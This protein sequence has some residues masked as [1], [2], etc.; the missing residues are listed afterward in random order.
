MKVLLKTF[1]MRTFLR[2]ADCRS[3]LLCWR[4]RTVLSLSLRFNCQQHSTS[5]ANATAECTKFCYSAQNTRHYNLNK[6]YISQV[7][8]WR[9]TLRNWRLCQ[10]QSHLTQKLGQISKIWPIQMYTLYPSLRIR[11]RTS[12]THFIKSTQKSKPKKKTACMTHSY[13][14]QQVS[15]QLHQ[16]LSEL[17]HAG[18]WTSERT[19]KCKN[20][21]WRDGYLI[22]SN[23]APAVVMYLVIISIMIQMNNVHVPYTHNCL[24]K[25]PVAK[26]S[27]SV[28]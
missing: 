9:S 3:N 15:T 27:A 11:G 2:S 14:I 1:L 23:Q 26:T 24:Q 10:V 18:P 7:R 21:D 6:K 17:F 5:I 22:K 13:F 16:T 28:E 8:D 12:E 25:I 20:W 19:F 4:R